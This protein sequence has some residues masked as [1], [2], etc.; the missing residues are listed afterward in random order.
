MAIGG[1]AKTM[2]GFADEVWEGMSKGVG[3]ATSKAST[4]KLKSN[5]SS[6]QKAALNNINK[7]VGKTAQSTAKNIVNTKTV[8]AAIDSAK[9]INVDKSINTARNT[10]GTR[11]GDNLVGGYRDTVKGMKGKDLSIANVKTAANT[12][13]RNKDGSMN[14]GRVAGAV[15]TAGVAGRVATGG[16]LYRDR[17]GSVNIPGVPLI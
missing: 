4:V 1:L 2:L 12:A 11:L 10:F 14:V 17:N 3:S 6:L 5:M 15:V 13:F 9:K 7:N 16:G 8:D